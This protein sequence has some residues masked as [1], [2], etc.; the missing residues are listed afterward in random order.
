MVAK[1]QILLFIAFQKKIQLQYLR[2]HSKNKCQNKWE[3][4]VLPFDAECH[5]V[6][7]IS[8]L[9]IRNMLMIIIY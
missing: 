2:G 1:L 7:G 8:S 9:A 5:S 3:G 4:G 6:C